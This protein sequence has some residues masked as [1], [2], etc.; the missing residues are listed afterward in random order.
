MGSLTTLSGHRKAQAGDPALF[1]QAQAGALL[2]GQ[3]VPTSNNWKAACSRLGT[4]H[5]WQSHCNQDTL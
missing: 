5:L 1:P 2:L 3:A 4:E